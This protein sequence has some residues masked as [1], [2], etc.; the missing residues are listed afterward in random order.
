MKDVVEH[1]FRTGQEKG[2]GD[3]HYI[4]CVRVA[5]ATRTHEKK[6]IKP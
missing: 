1:N 6:K 2:T 5:R 3:I 4:I